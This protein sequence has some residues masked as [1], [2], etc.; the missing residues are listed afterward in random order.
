MKLPLRVT[1][2]ALALAGGC[3]TS[4]P[5]PADAGLVAPPLNPGES[6]DPSVAPTVNIHFDPESIVLAPGESRPV[7]IIIDPDLCT[8]QTATFEADDSLV[9]I[10]ASADFDLRHPTY[11]LDVV[12]SS[13]APATVTSTKLVV[14]LPPRPANPSTGFA[15]DPASSHWTGTLPIQIRSAAVPTCAAGDGVTLSPATQLSSSKTTLSGKGTLADTQISVP[16]GA[17]TRTDE[18]AIAPFQAGIA[19]NGADIL[20]AGGA[21]VKLGPA[22]T[23]QPQDP[24]W[25]TH[26]LKRELQFSIPINPATMPTAARL[27]HLAVIYSGPRARTGRAIPIANPQLVEGADHNWALSFD[28]PWFGTYQAAVL[29]SAGTVSFTRHLT[30]RAVVGF[31]MGGGGSALL[32]INHH[33]QFDAIA[34]MGGNSDLTWLVWYFEQFKFGGFCPVSQPNCTIPPP[35]LYTL[36]E[37]YA[38]TEDFDHW[39]FQP[40][41]GTGGTFARGDWTQILEDFSIMGGNPNGQNADPAIP[42]MVVGPKAT[43]PFVAGTVA[44]TNCSITIDPIAPDSDDTPAMQA[45][46]AITE[47]QQQAT[48]SACLASRCDPKNAWIAKTGFYDASYNP[49][50]SLPVISFC[51]GGQNGTSPYVDTWAPSSPGNQVPSNLALAVDLNGNGIRDLGEPVIRQGTEP[52]T[53]TG[54]DGKADADEPN[55]DPIANPDP[56]QDDYDFALNPNGTENDHVYEKGEPFQDVGLDGVPNTPQ[57]AQGGYDV[58]E[59]DGVFTMA[60]G[61]QRLYTIDPHSQLHGRSTPAGGVIDAA[62]LS[63]LSFW[64]DGGVRDMANFGAVANHFVGAVSSQ[65]NSNGTPVKPTT[66]YNN[67]ENLPGSDPTQPNQ[68]LAANVLWNDVPTS[69]HLRYGYVDATPAMIAQGDGQHVGTGTQILYRLV[70]SFYFAANA[71]PDAD[72]TL[73]EALI[74][75]K[76]QPG[77]N[78]ETTTQNELGVTCELAGHCETYFTGPK[79]GRTGPIAIT[80]PPGYAIAANKA[81]RYPVLFVLHGYGQDPRDLEATAAVTDNYESDRQRSAATRLAKMIVVY[82]DGRCR[83]DP[84]TNVP[85]CI[86]GTFDVNSPRVVDNHPVGR[87]DDWFEEVMQY[88]DQNYR[89]L[90]PSDVN[91]VE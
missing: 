17:F 44:G 76:T 81:Q 85:E 78:A 41:S 5:T 3:S 64:A 86:R 58:G 47:K 75:D 87:I 88:I 74:T 21:Y 82:P 77:Y 66:F 70:T 29:A 56:D 49:T 53:D 15:G 27:R 13:S 16:P 80:L 60:S 26:S 11:A 9:T 18:L 54:T 28:S 83:I 40:G 25:A 38:H 46:E 42:F 33:D 34:P 57:Q 52:F 37:T 84:V 69:A 79:T 23:F 31:S 4:S 2:A 65:L 22:V 73:S 48:Q 89:T 7:R 12:A 51:D 6:C 20:P 59:G 55:Y 39:F 67:F 90:G 35:N 71:W 72:R 32:G 91:V 36:W 62:A 50:G 8:P 61:A 63:R 45:Q 43:D 10:P 19:C 14:T 1:W 68:Y 30:H 24:S